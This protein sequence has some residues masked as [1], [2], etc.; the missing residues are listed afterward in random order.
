MTNLADGSR[1]D[2]AAHGHPGP[3]HLAAHR[4][5]RHPRTSARLFYAE[6]LA[7]PGWESLPLTVA[8]QRVQVSA[9]PDAYAKWVDEA[10][11]VVGSVAGIVCSE[12]SPGDSG[13]L[14]P[15]PLA[16]PVIDRAVSQVGVD[17]VW[18]GG[19]AEGPTGGGFDCAGSARCQ[20]PTPEARAVRTGPRPR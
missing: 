13:E 15:N 1:D 6:L 4:P 10:S 5:R 20:R 18:G 17:Y 12:E 19:N 7:Q 14:P 16:Q 2:R 3:P 9:F 8:A 11:Q